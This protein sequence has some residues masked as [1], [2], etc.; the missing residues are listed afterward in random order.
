MAA[1]AKVKQY[2]DRATGEKESLDALMKR[3]KKEVIKSCVLEDCKRHQ[4]HMSKKE[5]RAYKHDLLMRHL[6]NKKYR[7]KY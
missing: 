7:I 1:N 4:Y 2:V 6:K 3:F 5:L